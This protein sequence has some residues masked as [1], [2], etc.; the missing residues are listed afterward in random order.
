M[1]NSKYRRSGGQALSKGQEGERDTQVRRLFA[2]P[3]ARYHNAVAEEPAVDKQLS[4]KNNVLWETTASGSVDFT[5]E[6]VCKAMDARAGDIRSHI[7]TVFLQTL[8]NLNKVIVEQANRIASL[9]KQVKRN[10]DIVNAFALGS[11]RGKDSNRSMQALMKAHMKTLERYLNSDLATTVGM[12][13]ICRYVTTRYIERLRNQQTIIDID[14]ILMFAPNAANRRQARRSIEGREFAKLR[15]KLLNSLALNCIS[16]ARKDVQLS[17]EISNGEKESNGKDNAMIGLDMDQVPW[18]EEGLVTRKSLQDV[19][20]N[21]YGGE[22]GVV[23]AKDRA[24]NGRGG[25]NSRD[26]HPNRNNIG[27][28][29]LK[30]KKGG[31]AYET[32]KEELALRVGKEFWKRRTEW[33]NCARHDART[34]F[35]RL[36]GFIFVPQSNV[37]MHFIAPLS[38]AYHVDDLPLAVTVAAEA[39]PITCDNRNKTLLSG[40]YDSYPQLMFESTYDVSIF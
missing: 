23:T 16:K 11:S 28:P 29:N 14:K 15:R 34:M 25:T 36:L 40:L 3:T 30:R 35:T 20:D 26:G 9:E 5:F 21:L 4:V 37:A 33:L 22:N 18:A 10:N 7:D 19:F 6:D 32:E 8:T 38:Y 39:N 31:S 2:R 1:T 12:H 27:E 13:V 24:A 17:K